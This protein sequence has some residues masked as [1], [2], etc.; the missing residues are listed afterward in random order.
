MYNYKIYE[1]ISGECK[2]LWEE[3]EKNSCHNFFQSLEY[4]QEVIKKNKKILLKIIIIFEDKNVVAILPLEIKSLFFFETLQWIGTEKSD[5]CNPIISKNFYNIIDKK[6]FIKLW[7]E[8][9][10][11]IGKFDIFFFNNQPLYIEEL[12]NPFVNFF[13]TINFSNIYQIKLPDTYEKYKNNIRD[14]DKKH[15][16]EIHRTSIKLSNLEKKSSLIFEVNN[17]FEKI[18]ELKEIIRDKI[19]L[20]K[21]KK[22][23]NNLNTEFIDI[24]ENLI[25]LKK[26]KFFLMNLYVDNKIISSCFGILYKNIFYYFV[27]ML[28]SNDYNNFKPGKILILKIIE[29]SISKKIN[30]FDFGLGNERYKKDFSNTNI[31]LHRYLNYRTLR[32]YF[33]CKFLILFYKRLRSF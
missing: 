18:F 24:Y 26:N 28:N 32:G 23:K 21:D 14:K 20:L 10:K 19:N 6:N 17:S 5:Y 3:V 31:S 25:N 7:D 16:Y 15:F 13:P 2:K 27:P 9:L 12:N 8:I 1:E 4:I 30:I 11:K 22:I 33:V 29:W